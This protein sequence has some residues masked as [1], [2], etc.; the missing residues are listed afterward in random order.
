MTVVSVTA[1]GAF[2]AVGS[3]LVV[4]LMVGPP[5]AAYLLTDRLALMLGLSVLIGRERRRRL[6]ACQL[7]GR[8]DCRR[9]GR[10]WPGPCSAGVWLAGTAAGPASRSCDGT[11]GSAG[12]SRRARLR[13]TYCSHENQPEAAEESEVEHLKRH[14]RWDPDFAAKVVRQARRRGLVVQQDGV[15]ALTDRGRAVADELMV[16]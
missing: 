15:L 9:H 12:N 10:R 11:P 1:V 16:R 13:S 6:L 5:A 8:V 7:A 14:L 3:M 2:D 4:A